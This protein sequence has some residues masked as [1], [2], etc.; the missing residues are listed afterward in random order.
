[1]LLADGILCVSEQAIMVRG[2]EERKST[3]LGLI[4]V[5][6]VIRV[7]CV[8][9]NSRTFHLRFFWI[10]GSIWTLFCLVKDGAGRPVS[11]PPSSGGGGSVGHGDGILG[12]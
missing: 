6:C 2:C 10:F 8:L 7:L 1:M 9:G 11:I 4:R 12:A 3:I 5:P